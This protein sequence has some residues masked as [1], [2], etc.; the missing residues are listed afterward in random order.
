MIGKNT[1]QR[2]SDDIELEFRVID[3]VLRF[4]DEVYMP[5]ESELKQM[6]LA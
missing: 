6:I 4:R 3:G 5:L 1:I 2:A